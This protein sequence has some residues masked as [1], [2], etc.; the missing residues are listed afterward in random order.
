LNFKSAGINNQR[1][2]N[3]STEYPLV[4]IGAGAA[5]LGASEQA[6][7][8]KIEHILLE[9]SHR[10]GGRG[11]TEYLEGEIPVDLGCHWMHSASI[12][13]YVDWAKKFGYHYDYEQEGYDYSLF[14]NGKWLNRGKCR[15]FERYMDNCNRKFN[16]IYQV[17]PS[18]SLLDAIDISSRWSQQ[19][20]YWMSLVCSNDVD[21]VSVADVA[22]YRE[23]DEDWPVKEG[24]GALIA[25]Q[26]ENCPVQL[27]TSVESIQWDRLPIQV[28]TNK[29]RVTAD[30]VIITVSTG[31]LS[32][33][34]IVF[35]PALPTS[36]KAAIEAL[37]MGN[38]NYQIFSMAEDA[39]DDDVPENIHYQD[40]DISMA[41]RIRPFDTPCVFTSTGGRFAWWLEKQG[42][43][44]SR[45][46]FQ[47][48][49]V[50]IFGSS[51]RT[52]L[53][54]FKVSAWGF[55]PWIRGAYS[56]LKPGYT[57]MRRQL[58]EPVNQRL[59]FAGEATSLDAFNCAHGAYQSGKRA[60]EETI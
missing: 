51:I 34:Q 24:Y 55:D 54:E 15:E 44:A 41:I 50:K 42:P 19:F 1:K 26:G 53:K 2:M 46:Y 22:E 37:P 14:F 6:K 36:K 27:N 35:N 49:L 38:S 5:G 58:A 11:L 23:T 13:P 60:V 7:K 32:T 52:K 8:L 31:I 4:I 59:F 47:E 28:N 30:K 33:G 16:E 20:C 45:E 3:K 12:N 40:G 9:A 17:S 48:A 25:K 21:Q 10:I 43:Q 18:A 29:G 39:I 56:S 57:G